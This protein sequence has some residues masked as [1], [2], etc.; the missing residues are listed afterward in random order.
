MVH[1]SKINNASSA[2]FILG[3]LSDSEAEPA[4]GTPNVLKGLFK[5]Y[6]LSNLD[7]FM[8]KLGTS[9]GKKSFLV[10]KN[11]K[12]ISILTENI[13]YFSVRYDSTII[14]TFDKQEYFV[15][16]SL[17][18]IQNLLPGTQFFRINRQYLASFNAIKEAEHYFARKLLI[19]LT[20][21]TRDK[22]IVSK[23]R[24]SDFLHWL[25][26]R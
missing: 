20:I 7:D 12:Y 8:I 14:V 1:Q 25:D 18:Q 15:N 4:V 9:A 21:P 16:Y 6:H 10:F 26:N 22:L 13:A 5:Q 11:N 2:R 3:G 17:E 24:V 19:N 23:E